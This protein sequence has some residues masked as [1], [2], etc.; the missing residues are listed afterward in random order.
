MSEAAA[1]KLRVLVR[2]DASVETGT[3]H[4]VR[5]ATLAEALSK[6][7]AEVVF[8]CRDLPGHLNDWLVQKGF[9]VWTWA[10]A[11]PAGTSALFAKLQ[12]VEH[13]PFDWLIVDHYGLDS[14]WENQLRPYARRVLV[15]DDLANRP[16]DCDALLDPNDLAQDPSRYRGLVPEACKLLLGPQYALLRSEFVDWRLKIL[17]SNRR[18]GQ[19]IERLLVFFG[20]SD[21]TGETLKTMAALQSLQ[22]PWQIDVV[23]G[24]GN[25]QRGQIQQLCEA[26]PQ[27]HFF[28]QVENM[29]ERMAVADFSI[30]AGG[31]ATWERLCLGLSTVVIAVAENQ[32]AIGKQVANAGAQMFLGAHGEVSSSMLKEAL[33]ML[34]NQSDQR[35]V[36]AEKALALVDGLGAQRVANYLLG[37]SS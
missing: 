10:D 22:P 7:G 9:S 36:M 1:L 19:T 31:T 23:V 12:A 20:G 32:L 4:V 27:F 34:A 21:P 30:G 15:M 33:L 17:H 11:D 35:I 29:A 3:G 24:A 5:C 8:V 25:P 6:R 2:A 26:L 28:C 37:K 13:L 16:H 18:A 14:H